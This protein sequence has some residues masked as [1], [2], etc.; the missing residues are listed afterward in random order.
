MTKPLV[1][2]RSEHSLSRTGINQNALKVLYRL[3]EAGYAAYLVGGCVRDMLLGREPKDFDVSTDA[4]PEQVKAQFRNCR[5]IG[6]RF[7]LA[8]VHFGREIIEVATFRALA[9]DG[10]DSENRLVEDGRIIRDNVYGTVEEDAWRRDFT[11]NALYYNIDDFSVVDYVGGVEDLRAGVLR[12]IGDPE[13]RYREDPVRML[14][15]VRFAVK[16]GFRLHPQTEAPLRALAPLLASISPARLYEEVLKLFLGGSA[17]QTVEMLRHYDL[18]QHLFPATERTM[19]AAREGVPAAM[20]MRAAANT[21]ARIAQDKPVTPAFLYA[22]FLWAPM[23][24]RALE[25]QEQ[26][27]PELPAQQ[28]AAGEVMQEQSQHAILPR[29][30]AL[31]M[32]EIWQMQ[33]RLQRNAG[34]KALRLLEHPR[35]RAAYDFLL[36]RCE[37][38]EELRELCEWWT[39]MQETDEAGRTTLLEQPA[40]KPA[41]EGARRRRRRGGRRRGGN[42]GAGEPKGDQP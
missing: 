14:R 6:R 29:R 26:G 20:V 17:E 34:K 25:L 41:G 33:P 37:A 2:P 39:S 18:F 30:Y 21:D 3:R 32:R 38:G 7:H 16:L 42:A 28:Q 23:R 9:S 35:F 15:A 36:L 12:L 10:D 13:T 31:P 24:E 8:H 40:A 5:L 19:S 4:H 22:A 27:Q 1:I 11:V